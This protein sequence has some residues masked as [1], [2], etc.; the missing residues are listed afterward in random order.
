MFSLVH[1]WMNVKF[2]FAILFWRRQSE[3]DTNL[4]VSLERACGFKYP[5]PWGGGFGL[6]TSDFVPW[7]DRETCPFS[8]HGHWKEDVILWF[9]GIAVKSKADRFVSIILTGCLRISKESIFTGVNNFA[10]YTVTSRKFSQ[11]FGLCL[12]AGYDTMNMDMKKLH[13]WIFKWRCHRC[14]VEDIIYEKLMC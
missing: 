11:Y 13:S 4:F 1:S 9:C 10:C 7:G 5:A 14:Y 3:S 6:G 8:A 12:L 2:F